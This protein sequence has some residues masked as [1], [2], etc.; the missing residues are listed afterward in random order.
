MRHTPWRAR[1]WRTA[2]AAI[3]VSALVLL[4]APS[5]AS[6]YDP[7]ADTQDPYQ[8]PSISNSCAKNSSPVASGTIYG[9]N[10]RKLGTGYLYYSWTCGTN[11]TEV[12]TSVSAGG[13][14]GWLWTEVNTGPPFEQQIYQWNGNFPIGARS[15]SNMVYAPYACAAGTIAIGL[16]NG[17]EGSV[18]LMDPTC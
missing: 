4:G 2:I 7:G 15:W 11:W 9:A 1:G 16:A 6:A 10:S 17:D 8:Y 18:N 3:F 5:V 13:S 14:S 12:K